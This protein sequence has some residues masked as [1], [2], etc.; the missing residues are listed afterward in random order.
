[1]AVIGR[2]LPAILSCRVLCSEAAGKS[3]STFGEDTHTARPQALKLA[4][5]FLEGMVIELGV[6]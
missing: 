2:C 6:D 5:C 4:L 3:P 1:M